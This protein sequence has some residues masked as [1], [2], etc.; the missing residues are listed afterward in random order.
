[1]MMAGHLHPPF[2]FWSCQKENGPCTVQKKKTLGRELG[3]AAKFRHVRELSP[4]GLGEDLGV[5]AGARRTGSLV[6]VFPRVKR[7]PTEAVGRLTNGPASLSALPRWLGA[8]GTSGLPRTAPRRARTPGRAIPPR[9]LQAPLRGAV[10]AAI[11]RPSSHD[12]RISHRT[13]ER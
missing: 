7:L 5:P 8:P 2:S 4:P 12:I 11:S 3:R 1:M 13:G 9:S 10:G 6:G